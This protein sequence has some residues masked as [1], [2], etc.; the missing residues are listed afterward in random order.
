MAVNLSDIA[1]MGAQPAFASLALSMPA[2]D[3]SW[4]NDFSQGLFALCDSHNVDLI[5]GDL[6]RGPLSITVQLMG[7]VPETQA[8]QRNGARVGDAIYVTGTL[9]DAALALAALESGDDTGADEF[10]LRRLNFPTARVEA[11]IAL[12]GLATA[13]IDVSDGLATDLERILLQSGVGAQVELDDLP[14]SVA[15]RRV[16]GEQVDWRLPVNGG[17]DFELLFTVPKNLE[18]LVADRI[19]PFCACSRIGEISVDS[20]LEIFRSGKPMREIWQGFDHFANAS[21]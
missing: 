20:G 15:F 8:I 9:G 14:L 16:S 10:L 3:E 5:G 19:R 4:L 12:R 18:A 6:V 13:A 11:G 17:D 21:D 7:F 1:A 2:V